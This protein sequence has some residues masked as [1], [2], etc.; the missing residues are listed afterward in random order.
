MCVCPVQLQTR[1]FSGVTSYSVPEVLVYKREGFLAHHYSGDPRVDA[2][3]CFDLLQEHI[4]SFS[5][6]ENPSPLQHVDQTAS[7]VFQVGD[8]RA[9]HLI[10]VWSRAPCLCLCFSRLLIRRND[11]TRFGAP[12]GCSYCNK[13]TRLVAPNGIGAPIG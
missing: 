4:V 8:H 2:A 11:C 9:R 1:F 10:D 13:C 5:V 12:N 7:N 6:G 3:R